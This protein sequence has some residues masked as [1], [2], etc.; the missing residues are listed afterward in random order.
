METHPYCPTPAAC[1]AAVAARPRTCRG[2]RCI[3]TL[4]GARAT[5]T[6]TAAIIRP[7]L[8]LLLL[9][10]TRRR[11]LRH[12]DLV[13]TLAISVLSVGAASALFYGLFPYHW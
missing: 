9:L 8:L 7:R 13:A 10:H 5:V 12:G 2:R 4:A 1:I 3:I 6:T 11:S